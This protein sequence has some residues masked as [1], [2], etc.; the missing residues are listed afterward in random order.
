M[1]PVSSES[2][3]ETIV[4]N[5]SSY[6]WLLSDAESNTELYTNGIWILSQCLPYN[7]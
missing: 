2:A 4:L 3:R 1:F 6:Q 5:S 7:K